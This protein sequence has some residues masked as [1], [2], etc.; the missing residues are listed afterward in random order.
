MIFRLPDHAFLSASVP[1]ASRT[2]QYMGH[3]NETIEAEAH[4]TIG[5]A[6]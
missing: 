2:M 1:F 3:W 5:V 4:V 6:R